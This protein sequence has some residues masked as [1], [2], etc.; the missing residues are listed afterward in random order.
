MK[1]QIRRN[2]YGVFTAA[3]LALAGIASFAGAARLS[4]AVPVFDQVPGLTEKA[5][6]PN[7]LPAGEGSGA[8]ANP[9]GEGSAPATNED[10]LLTSAATNAPATNVLKRAGLSVLDK[11][12]PG[13]Q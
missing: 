4:G 7:P 2:V 6:S 12:K 10:R 1:N 13:G 11:V 9:V 3:A 5:P 8:G